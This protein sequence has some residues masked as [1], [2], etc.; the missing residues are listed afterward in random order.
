MLDVAKAVLD[1]A[2]LG[3][4][5]AKLTSPMRGR[6]ANS[7]DLACLSSS[8][9][10]A[11]S[12]RRWWQAGERSRRTWLSISRSAPLGEPDRA[13]GLRGA[14]EELDRVTATTVGVSPAEAARQ[15]LGRVPECRFHG[16]RD[17][18][19]GWNSGASLAS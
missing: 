7:L 18:Q 13:V 17:S 4:D 12:G 15:G 3:H 19:E 8:A 1:R 16:S 14:A 10:S 5:L 9:S 11:R 2:D 6:G